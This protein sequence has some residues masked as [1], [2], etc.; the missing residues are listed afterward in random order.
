MQHEEA[1]ED[2]GGGWQTHQHSDQESGHGNKRHVWGE[3]KQGRE[4]GQRVPSQCPRQGDSDQEHHRNPAERMPDHRW[5][6]P[7]LGTRPSPAHL[8]FVIK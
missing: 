8:K 5:D 1:G 7:P 6:A 4:Q 3:G 2:D